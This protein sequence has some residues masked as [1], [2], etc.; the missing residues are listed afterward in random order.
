MDLN[1]MVLLRDGMGEG[2]VARG[3]GISAGFLS[4]WWRRTDRM[5]VLP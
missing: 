5:L 3:G 1:L 2:E 4:R